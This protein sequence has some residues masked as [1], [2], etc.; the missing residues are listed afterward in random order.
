MVPE[1]YIHMQ[2]NELEHFTHTIYKTVNSKWIKDLHVEFK[3]QNL[4]L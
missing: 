3:V 4:K 2:K 1:L